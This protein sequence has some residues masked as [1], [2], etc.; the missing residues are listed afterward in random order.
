MR[1]ST[2]NN[3]CNDAKSPEKR[4]RCYNMP[5]PISR[6]TEAIERADALCCE[7]PGDEINECASQKLWVIIHFTIPEHVDCIL[8][9]AP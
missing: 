8:S 6:E 9:S 4:E 1:D 7:S 5:T 3:G 2:T